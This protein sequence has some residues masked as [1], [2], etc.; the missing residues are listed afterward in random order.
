MI[1]LSYSACNSTDSTLIVLIDSTSD[2]TGNTCDSTCNST[3]LQ[4]I[5][6][7][8]STSDSTGSTCDSTNLHH[9]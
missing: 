6:S 7:T 4:Y 5:N 3:D 9:M 2:S 8:D 1:V